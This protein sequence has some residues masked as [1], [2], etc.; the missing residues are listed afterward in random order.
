MSKIETVGGQPSRSA[1]YLKILDLIRELESQCAVMAHLHNT[2][3]NDMD[4]ILARGWLGMSELFN[5]AA[6]QITRLAMNKLN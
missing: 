3:G 1:T 4:K 2:E 5:R 6:T